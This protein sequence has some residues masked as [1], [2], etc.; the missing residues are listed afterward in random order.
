M[1][2]Y[3]STCMCVYVCM[4]VCVFTYGREGAQYFDPVL[5]SERVGGVHAGEVGQAGG[6]V[7]RSPAQDVTQLRRVSVYGVP[8]DQELKQEEGRERET[9]ESLF[10]ICQ[11]SNQPKQI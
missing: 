8:G 11:N 1:H 3:A 9:R 5:G 2:M 4:C 7:G 10:Q 6:G